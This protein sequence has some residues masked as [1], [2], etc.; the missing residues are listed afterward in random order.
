M[1]QLHNLKS[2]RPS[3]KQILFGGIGGG[4]GIMGIIFALSVYIV[5][6]LTRPQKRTAFDLYKFSPFELDLPAEEV[7]FPPKEGDHMVSGWYIPHP[8]ATTTI[9]ICPGYRTTKHDVIG[10]SAHLWKAG[11]N[12]LAFEYHGHGAPVGKSVTLGYSEI[13]DF[14]GAITYAKERAPGTRLGVVAYSMGAAIAIMAMARVP[15]IEVL[16]AD[17]PFATHSGAV[18]YN[19]HRIFHLPF[20]TV[21]WMAD[22][23]LGIRA[24]Y[25]FHQVEPLRDIAKIAPR[26]ILLIHGMKDT[27]V[28]PRDATLLY[29]AAGEPKELWLSP[30][31]DHC[32]VYFEDRAAYVKKVASFFDLH[33]KNVP[34]L[35]LLDQ[36]TMTE[37]TALPEEDGEENLPEAS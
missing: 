10:I 16:V 24:G 18:A 1:L 3:L 17:S 30:N 21:A 7:L 31:A 23:L 4:V 14:F 35:S 9:I 33:L 6:M 12:I 20:A 19:F 15:E 8:G 2:F 28:D 27:I 22:T 11:H 37:I 36:S 29:N 25:R 13:R 26:P 5:E 32:G 34:Q